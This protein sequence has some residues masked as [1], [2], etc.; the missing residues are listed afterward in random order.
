[1]RSPHHHLPL[2]LGCLA[3]AACGATAQAGNTGTGATPSAHSGKTRDFEFSDC[4]RSHGVS[5][6]PD[7]TANGLQL[8]A[9]INAQSPA[10]QAAQNACKQYLPNGGAPPATPAKD[11]A[12]ALALSRCMRTHGVPQFPDP[13]FSPPRNAR[14]ILLVRG[15]AFAIPASVDPKSPAYIQAAG[16]CGYGQP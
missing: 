15:M 5:N 8:P 12:A 11:R 10:F 9:S 2:L 4:M 16:A 13:T 1:M 7:P 14:T 6:F 3:L